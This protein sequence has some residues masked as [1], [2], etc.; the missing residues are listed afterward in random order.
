MPN[1]FAWL[2]SEAV[3]AS[4]SAPA[5]PAAPAA[6]AAPAAP[7]PA[8]PPAAAVMPK[9]LDVEPSELVLTCLDHG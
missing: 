6:A 5:A 8:P 1:P 9:A 2:S 3:E 7:A 4:A